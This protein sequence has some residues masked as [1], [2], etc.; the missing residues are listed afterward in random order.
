MGEPITEGEGNGGEDVWLLST[1]DFTFGPQGST[2][3]FDLTHSTLLFSCPYKR[4]F[5]FYLFF[6]FT[7]SSVKFEVWKRCCEEH[8]MLLLLR[9]WSEHIYSQGH[10][11]PTIREV[12]AAKA[13]SAKSNNQPVVYLLDRHMGPIGQSHTRS[14]Y[15]STTTIASHYPQYF[16]E[17]NHLLSS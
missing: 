1:F 8:L 10:T 7:N 12:A 11:V 14:S 15:F 5:P 4:G 16:L 3:G 2:S 6:C 17:A 13:T 9:P